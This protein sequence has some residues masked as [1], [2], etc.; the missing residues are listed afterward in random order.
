VEGLQDPL[1]SFWGP[2]G[3][4]QE[5]G[6]KPEVVFRRRFLTSLVRNLAVVQLQLRLMLLSD[7]NL[8]MW[9]TDCGQTQVP[10]FLAGAYL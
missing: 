1:T 2:G 3:T 9:A 10:D 7:A 4:I 8:G 5:G 6:C